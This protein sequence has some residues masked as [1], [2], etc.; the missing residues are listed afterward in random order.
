MSEL[1]EGVEL[2]SA[3]VAKPRPSAAAVISRN[4]GEDME[5]LLCHRVSEVPS[6][7]DFWAF[8]G[9][10]ISRVD[11]KVAESN[12]SWF[13]EREDREWLIALLREML[14]E[15][16]VSPDGNG[17]FVNVEVEIIDRVNEDKSEWSKLVFEN[18]LSIDNFNPSLITQR[19]TPP[20]API[21]HRNRFYHV[22]TGDNSIEPKFPSGRTEF[23]EFQWWKPNELLDAWLSHEVKLPPPQVTLIRGI[24]E[25]GF[26]ELAKNPPSGYHRIEYANGVELVP[27]PTDTLPPATHT[28]CYVLGHPGGS[29]ILVDPAARS[30]EALEILRN[31]V[32]EIEESGSKIIA[33]VFT[34]KHPDHIGDLGKI[35]K[36]YRA[37]IFA[38]EET[39]SDF[40]T[41]TPWFRRR[42]LSEGDIIKIDDEKWSVI[43]THGHCRGHICLVGEAGIVSGDNA[44][45][46]GT[47][48]V[49]SSDGNMNEYLAGLERLRDLDP[50]LLFPGHG[51]MVANPRRLLTR[52]LNHRKKRH[53]R[54][55]NAVKVMEDDGGGTL[56][57][58]TRE[59]Y[60]DTPDA[61]PNLAM[62][63]TYS[64]LLALEESGNIRQGNGIWIFQTRE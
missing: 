20:V 44:V 24:V 28:D 61:H 26:S 9:G 50:S 62:D 51:P 21:R 48:L 1:P 23:D 18:K 55:L 6:F 34:H 5:I 33:T 38:S 43:E 10:G 58:I 53:L 31:K 45:L 15:V 37:P 32:A 3:E 16:G 52:Y 19:T 57:S 60:A 54:V 22:A 36:I 41:N 27:I 49:P 8:P 39:L 42:T 59:A 4:S 14:E 29:R 46:F 12:P 64:H 47:I 40:R 7:P 56:E 13:S 30:I 25:L 11:R 2:P 35:S 17:E 63:Q